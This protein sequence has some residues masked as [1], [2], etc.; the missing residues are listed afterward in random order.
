MKRLYWLGAL[1]AAVL[2]I[3]CGGGG[4]SFAFDTDD[5][6][7]AAHDALP[8]DRD[9]R[10]FDV[11]SEDDF[12]DGRPDS[13]TR[14]CR[15]V[16]RAIEARD[17]HRDDNL[18]GR[19]NVGLSHADKDILLSVTVEV[20]VFKSSAIAK[21]YLKL[22]G[23]FAKHKDL[24]ECIED[25]AE[26]PVEEEK[27]AAA[28]PRNGISASLLIEDSLFEFYAWQQGNGVVTVQ[29]NGQDVDPD[30]IDE[31]VTKVAAV[32]DRATKR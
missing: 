17:D 25:E 30:L 28:A 23:A 11:Q 9:L 8:D 16:N 13:D 31:V 21:E 27:P 1:G 15:A 7:E 12:D 10:D 22:V 20:F 2:L 4:E 6:D 14:A 3:A 5:A 19:A 32:V 29:F 24:A 18:E 26:E